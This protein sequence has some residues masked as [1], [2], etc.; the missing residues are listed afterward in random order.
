MKLRSLI[1]GAAGAIGLTTVANRVLESR[2]STFEPFLDGEQHTY[3]WRGFDV[4]YTEMGDPADDDVLLFHGISAASSNHEF[5][6]LAEELREDYH[7]IA[8]DLPGFGHSDR[9][10]LLYSASLY[11]TFVADAIEELSDEDPIVVGSSLTGAYVGLA[12]ERV[13]VEELLLICPTDSTM[14]SRQGWV[15]ALFRS[16][17][18]GQGL[19]NLLVSKPAIRHFQADHGYYDVANFD[20]EVLDYEWLTAHQ[21]GARYAPAS[22]VSGFLDPE[23]DLGGALADLEA[24]VTFV[25]GRQTSTTPLSQG[26]D[27]AESAD[28]GLVVFDRARLLPHVEHPA[29]FA[30]LIREEGTPTE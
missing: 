21:P 6:R 14:G 20:D 18:L 11:T 19:F 5:D 22:F 23:D 13:D 16:P 12:A 9:P 8:P 4:A 15:R 17:I 26:R 29:Q 2:A 10:P 7:V 25:W 27:L 3:R 1:G 24:P 28:V 30:D